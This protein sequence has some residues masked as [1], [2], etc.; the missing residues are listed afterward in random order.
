MILH[1]RLGKEGG[2]NAHPLADFQ[3]FPDGLGGVEQHEVGLG[4]RHVGVVVGTQPPVKKHC[5]FQPLHLPLQLIPAQRL[6]PAPG[7]EQEVLPY[8]LHSQSGPPRTVPLYR[9]PQ[10]AFQGAVGHRRG[11]EHPGLGPVGGVALGDIQRPALGGAVAVQ[12][13]HQLA[14]AAHRQALKIAYDAPK[15]PPAALAQDL[16]AAGHRVPRPV[17]PGAVHLHQSAPQ[18]LGQAYA[19]QSGPRPHPVGHMGRGKAV[20]AP[21]GLP[22]GGEGQ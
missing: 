14:Q 9:L 7:G 19:K 5:G 18:P 12:N 10:A 20:A 22:P 6:P 1:L 11:N 2:G 3:L 13:F 15:G 21:P 17:E 16:A 8:P 4:S